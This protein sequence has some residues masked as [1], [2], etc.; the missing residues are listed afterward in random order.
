MHINSAL[1]LLVLAT[2]VLPACNQ[3]AGNDP[4]E[5]DAPPVTMIRTGWL[6][7]DDIMEASGIKA[8]FS[9][10]GDFFV[11]ND[12]GDPVLYGIDE[13]GTNLGSVTIVPAKNKDW[14]DITLVPVEGEHWIVVGDI[15]D[16]RAKRKSTKLYFIE[17]PKTGK[18]DR[19]GGRQDLKH[20]LTLKYPDGPRDCE[21][22]AYDPIGRQ[23]L[24]LTKR[25]KPSRLYALDL[26]TALTKVHA[27]LKFLGTIAKLRPPTSK[28]RIHW[29][30]RTDFISQPTGFDISPDG[31]EA[32]IITYRSLY[33]FRREP[34]EGWLS[35]LQRK[36]VEVGGPPS[37]QNEAI[38]YS[39]DGKAIYVTT[40]KRP[41][42]IFRF[43][44]THDEITQ[45]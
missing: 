19:Y 32:V 14:E 31:S 5:T 13:S 45:P 34:D 2:F 3:Q 43:E 26:E 27:E 18:H 36:P 25:D 28:D 16:N 17:E 37:V 23:I 22:M 29:H 11:H 41:A 12:E 15:G 42:P 39:V 6:E 20:A 33:R 21:A 4:V 44:F 24:F 30:G 1:S 7:S 8:S 9:H 10:P 40:E 35:A 38:S